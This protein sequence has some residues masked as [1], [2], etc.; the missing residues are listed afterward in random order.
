MVETEATVP[1]FFDSPESTLVMGA[2]YHPGQEVL[3]VTFHRGLGKTATYTY[4]G[5]PPALWAE[6]KDSASKGQFFAQRIRPLFHG[7]EHKK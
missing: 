4:D 6:F 3:M 7:K 1:E 5:I 2:A